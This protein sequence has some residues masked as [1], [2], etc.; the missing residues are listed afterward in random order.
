MHVSKMKCNRRKLQ[1][2]TFRAQQLRN[3]VMEGS[4]NIMTRRG[5][6]TE[7]GNLP[8]SLVPTEKHQPAPKNVSC[9]VP[10]KNLQVSAPTPNP[11]SQSW[12]VNIVLLLSRLITLTISI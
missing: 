1:H 6:W 10:K 4:V 11:A 2:G 3:I 5:K 7:E 9:H 12:G 8:A